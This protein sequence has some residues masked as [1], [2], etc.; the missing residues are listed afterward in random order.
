[1]KEAYDIIDNFGSQEVEVK[2][3]LFIYYLLFLMFV[4]LYSLLGF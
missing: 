4:N 3:Y 2:F 1:M